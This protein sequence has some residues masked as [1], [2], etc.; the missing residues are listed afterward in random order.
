MAV[1][2]S[3]NRAEIHAE[4]MRLNDEAISITKAD[5]RAAVDALDNFLESNAA[6]VNNAIPQ[7][8]RG[9]LSARQKAWIL[10]LVIERRFKV[11]A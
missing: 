6:A 10:A 5:L 4:W 11:G 8:A 1:L 2:S 9:A 7:P 3:E